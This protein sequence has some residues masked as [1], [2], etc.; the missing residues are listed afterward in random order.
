VGLKL[1]WTY[2]LLLF[3][4]D[5]NLLGDNIVTVAC[6]PV[7]RRRPRKKQLYN[8]RY[9]VTASQRSMFGTATEERCF[10]CGPCRGVVSRTVRVSRELL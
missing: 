5:V 2:E 8:S 3:A 7:A 1:N 10:L 6:R 4:D 9:R